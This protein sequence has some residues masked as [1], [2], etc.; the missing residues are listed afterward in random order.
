ME[1]RST[2]WEDKEEV[3]KNMFKKHC[4]CVWNTQTIDQTI[5]IKRKI[6]SNSKQGRKLL[7]KTL[8]KGERDWTLV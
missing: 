6:Q 4:M 8:S 2:P 7:L 5:F 1:W 3:E